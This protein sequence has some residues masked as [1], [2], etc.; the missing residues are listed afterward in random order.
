MFKKFLIYTG[1]LILSGVI[2]YGSGEI[3]P[4]NEITL[5]DIYGDDD[6]WPLI[7]YIVR[8]SWSSVPWFPW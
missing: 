3:F 6:F 2:W 8:I 7:V 1:K 4:D 5:N